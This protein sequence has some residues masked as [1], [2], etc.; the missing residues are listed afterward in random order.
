MDKLIVTV[1]VM[2]CKLDSTIIF[3]FYSTWTL[4]KAI[5]KLYFLE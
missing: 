3:C 1:A 2:M 4:W 5:S